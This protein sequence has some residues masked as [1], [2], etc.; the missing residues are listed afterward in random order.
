MR[1]E[2]DGHKNA[3]GGDSIILHFEDTKVINL[4]DGFYSVSETTICLEFLFNWNKEMAVWS[5]HSAENKEKIIKEIE[6]FISIMN[7]KKEVFMAYA[8]D[9]DC[10]LLFSEKPEKFK[11]TMKGGGFEGH[12]TTALIDDCPKRILILG[13]ND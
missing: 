2:N 6:H 9:T 8:Y 4:S 1:L 13:E 5:C 12:G 11:P 3:T 7:G 10:C